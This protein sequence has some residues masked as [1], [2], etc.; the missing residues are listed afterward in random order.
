[1]F[2]TD[3]GCLLRKADSG[4]NHLLLVVFLKENGLRNVLAR[5]R[6]KPEAGNHLPDLFE[7][8][9]FSIEQKDPARP[10]FLKEYAPLTRFPDIARSYSRLTCACQLTR[11]YERNLLHLEHF[12]S[13]WELLLTA[14]DAFSG[15]PDPE[16]TLLKAL[17]RF[18]RSEGYP[19]KAQWLDSLPASLKGRVAEALQKPVGAAPADPGDVR[20]W[21]RHLYRFFEQSTDLLP[22]DLQQT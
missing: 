12:P 19:V 4:E 9:E 14:L 21:T 22:P 2:L 17:Y 7:C 18:A 8:G 20:E 15:K 1:M 10:C 16:T 3:Q 13:V 5:K 11:F 6:V